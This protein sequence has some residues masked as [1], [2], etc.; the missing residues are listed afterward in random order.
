MEKKGFLII[1]LFLILIP[2]ISA[3]FGYD[4]PTLPKLKDP[5]A[6]FGNFTWNGGWQNGGVSIIDGDIYVQTGY[7]YNLTS[8]NITEQN[9]TI[10]E[11]L[12]IFED[13]TV[14]TDTLFVDSDLGRV[15]IGTGSP[16]RLL[17]VEMS[18][19]G[20]IAEFVSTHVG[21]NRYVLVDITQA[22]GTD[23]RAI[24]RFQNDATGY[25]I[26]VDDD[27]GFKISQSLGSDFTATK[28]TVQTGGNVGI[29]T[30]TPQN[31][32]NVIG[33]GNFTGNLT[34]GQKIT[35]A[36]GEI[37]DN[38]VDGWITITGN[39]NVKGAIS[40]A[41]LTVTESADNTSVSGVNIM[42]VNI[43]SNIV[44]GGLTG[45]VNGQVLH[46]GYMGNYVNTLT[47]EDTEGVG[48]Q[49]FYT[50][51]RGDET[52]DGGGYTFVCDGSNWYD[53]SHAKHV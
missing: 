33:D 45:G 10:I 27:D 5:N 13:L 47:V 29:G 53:A 34:L 35:F 41:T 3:P 17:D 15:G 19:S 24:L 39:L 21:A 49:D 46:V 2:C 6:F 50:H 12:D 38:I 23:T 20:V 4:N 7:F 1:A 40:S 37:I 26:G 44:L 9:L 30:S 51:T 18:V 8:L 25:S 36:F 16:T 32:L 52:V 31:T 43:T 48:D 28:F 14:G 11:N 42:F 22:S